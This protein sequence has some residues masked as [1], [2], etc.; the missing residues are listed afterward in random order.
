MAMR[1]FFWISLAGLAWL[2]LGYPLLVWVRARLRPRPVDMSHD[3]GGTLWVV[4]VAHEEAGALREKTR[5]LLA[6]NVADRIVDIVVA[7]DASTDATA[8]VLDTIPEDRSW[9]SAPVTVDLLVNDTEADEDDFMLLGVPGKYRM[10][11][12]GNPDSRRPS[13]RSKWVRARQGLDAVSEDWN[14]QGGGL[15][16]RPCPGCSGFRWRAWGT[17]ASAIRC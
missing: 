15:Y 3:P 16:S 1:A 12:R 11:D 8:M 7:G 9:G 5:R 6:S 13:R 4:I 2:Y 17:S 14:R 10:R